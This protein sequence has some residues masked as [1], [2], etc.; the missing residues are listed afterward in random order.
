MNYYSTNK[1]FHAYSTTKLLY[2]RY[3]Q[4]ATTE[5]EYSTDLVREVVGDNVSYLYNRKYSGLDYYIYSIRG[6]VPP[7]ISELSVL[8]LDFGYTP[9]LEHAKPMCY[10]ALFGLL[11]KSKTLC[12]NPIQSERGV[13]LWLDLMRTA[14]T[15]GYYVSAINL[16][17]NTCTTF[18]PTDLKHGSVDDFLGSVSDVDII[19]KGLRLAVH[20]TSLKGV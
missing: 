14:S 2:K 13:G 1:E 19:S 7:R 3:R 5:A 6:Y 10:G 4:N 16:N 20:E 11:R 17:T 8:Y 9:E 18:S 15:V 12:S